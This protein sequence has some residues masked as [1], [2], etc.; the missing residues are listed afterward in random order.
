MQQVK[1]ADKVEIIDEQAGTAK[2]GIYLIGAIILL[3][4]ITFFFGLGRLALTGPDEPRYAEVAR[5]MFV[6]GDYISPRLAGC[7]WYEKPALVY[8]MAAASYGIFGV[9]EFAARFPAALCALITSLVIFYVLN[10]A[11]YGVWA[12]SA[13]I[14]LAT[15]GLFIGFARAITMDLIFTWAIAIALIAGYRAGVAEG[16]ARLFYWAACGA[17]AGLSVLAKGFAGILLIGAILG[18]YSIVSGRKKAGWR[19]LA[20]AVSTL[21]AVA[22]A[23]YV[24][25]TVRHGQEFID[26]FVL[27]HHFERYLTT[28]HRHPQPVYFFLF[29][30]MAGLMP[31]TFLLIPSIARMRLLRPR[32]GERDSLL[33]FAWIW[34]GV[35]TLFFSLSGSKLPGYILP[36]FPA[37]A[38][39]IGAELERVWNGEKTPVIKIALWL[40]ALLLL[41][42]GVA[43][44]IYV[45]WQDGASAVWQR[46]VQWGPL[47]A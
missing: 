13:A 12:A 20:V 46:L 34:V 1:A 33:V 32:S 24:P 30:I 15:S 43:F 42:I 31:W 9:G 35:P 36:V 23:W 41:A 16:R 7:P 28:V 26:E 5:E 8:W 25:V 17:A 44:I 39:I 37:L 4:S 3:C 45:G 14:A 22:G 6:T 11:G 19:D 2:R 40:T 10:S 47:A 27:E 29:V 21:I 18:L 38:I